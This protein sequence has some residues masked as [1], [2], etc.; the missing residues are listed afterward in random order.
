MY[1]IS[2]IPF[3]NDFL[4]KKWGINSILMDSYITYNYK[5]V[6]PS[7]LSS[8]KILMIGRGNDNNKRFEKG[9]MSIEY[10]LQVIQDCELKIISQL[11][12][13]NALVNLID[14]LKL[15]HNINIEGFKEYS[16]TFFKNASLH[17]FPSIS[18]SFG[19]VLCETKIFR[20]FY[21]E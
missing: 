7:D 18:E 13:L 11:Y 14:N 6:Y 8:K 19:L 20:I 12:K 10:I 9:V 16:D 21:W 1:I 5:R 4:F 3:E 17:F 15:R 2:L